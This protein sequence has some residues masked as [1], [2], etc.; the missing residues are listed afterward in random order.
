M[1]LQQ[2][3]QSFILMKKAQW[4]SSHERQEEISQ[5]YVKKL[6]DLCAAVQSK[7]NM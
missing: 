6:Y 4:D 7:S 3:V 2:I 5:H 1:R